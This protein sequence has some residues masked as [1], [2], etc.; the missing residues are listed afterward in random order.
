MMEYSKTGD[1]IQ[2]NKQVVQTF[3]PDKIQMIRNMRKQERE[4]RMNSVVFN[5]SVKDQEEFQQKNFSLYKHELSKT[6]TNIQKLERQMKGK[7]I[8]CTSFWRSTVNLMH[9]LVLIDEFFKVRKK[10]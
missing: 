4:I 6:L 3:L 10:I 5:K 7:T 2:A 9:F 1:K 8:F